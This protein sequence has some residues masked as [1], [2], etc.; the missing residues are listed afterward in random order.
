MLPPKRL[1]I[2]LELPEE[3][4]RKLVGI[5]PRLPGL[6]WLPPE[7]IH[8]TLSFLGEVEGAAQER[9]G[10]ALA[11][12]TVPP[13]F[14]PLVGMGMFQAG[15]RPSVV[16]IGVGQGH[17]HLFALHH[18]VQ[19]A[20]LKAGIEPDLKPFHPHVTIARAKGISK[21]ALRPFIRKHA[22]DEHGLIHVKEFVVF[23]SVLSAG[24]A[25]HTEEL[26]ISL[27][28]G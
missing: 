21:E 14:L 16:W 12:V 13:F 15:G 18:H 3:T 10:E 27:G 19:D 2:G 22:E 1:F 28:G 7:Q 26:R 5:D 9:L 17:P 4:K 25:E 23:S 11:S 6:R 24:G 8:L 20:V